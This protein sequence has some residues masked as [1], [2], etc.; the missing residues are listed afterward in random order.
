MENVGKEQPKRVKPLSCLSLMMQWSMLSSLPVS[1]SVWR[2]KGKEKSHS[3]PISH[4]M[5]S[6]TN[7]WDVFFFKLGHWD[8][9]YK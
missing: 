1:F 3:Q 4:S 2:G 8:V 7:I 9:F 6:K 5:L